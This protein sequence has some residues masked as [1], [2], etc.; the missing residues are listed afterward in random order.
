MRSNVECITDP[1]LNT[2]HSSHI[3]YR[4]SLVTYHLIPI[5]S[6][7]ITYRFTYHLSLIPHHLSLITYHLSLYRLSPLSPITYPISSLSLITYHLSFI[8]YP[9]SSLSLITYHLSPINFYY[10][11]KF[12]VREATFNVREAT[13]NILNG[14]LPD[15]MFAPGNRVLSPIHLSPITN[16]S[17]FIPY[18]RRLKGEEGP[19]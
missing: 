12:V 17:S 2:Y 15:V 10:C 1:L 14:C 18:H 8:T 7:L 19:D 9:I 4:L 13:G 6:S 11:V 16:H 3:T 5:H